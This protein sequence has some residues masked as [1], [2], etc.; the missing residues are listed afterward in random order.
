[1]TPL[2]T[3]L[4]SLALLILALVHGSLVTADNTQASEPAKKIEPA[5]VSKTQ[6]VEQSADPTASKPSM[7]QDEFNPSEEISEDFPIPLPADI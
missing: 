1:M 5:A 3:G 6:S 7:N 4:L 2:R